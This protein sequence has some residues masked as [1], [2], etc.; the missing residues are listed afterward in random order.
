V[1]LFALLCSSLTRAPLS[2]V[3]I[4]VPDPIVRQIVRPSVK[5]QATS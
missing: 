2:R 4:R 3:A 1:F 5:A